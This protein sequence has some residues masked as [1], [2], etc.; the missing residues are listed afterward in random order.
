MEG[1]R[2]GFAAAAIETCIETARPI[3]MK[4]IPDSTLASDTAA[5]QERQKV[6]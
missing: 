6:R 1:K 3:A 2:G 5:E 4:Q